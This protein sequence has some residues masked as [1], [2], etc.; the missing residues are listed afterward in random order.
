MVGT[1]S[2][3]PQQRSALL[4]PAIEAWDTVAA[5]YDRTSLPWERN[6]VADWPARQPQYDDRFFRMWR[7]QLLWCAGTFHAR[8]NQLWQ[9]VLSW[10]GVPG[11]HRSIR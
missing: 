1:W 6:F 2:R 4:S 10:E 5:D 3:S 11:G 8:R 7:Y 9:L